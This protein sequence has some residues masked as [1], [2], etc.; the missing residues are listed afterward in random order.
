[1]FLDWCFKAFQMKFHSNGIKVQDSRLDA[2]SMISFSL[3]PCHGTYD[4]KVN[5]DQYI[6]HIDI[7][8]DSVLKTA[9]PKRAFAGIQCF[10]L[11][12][13]VTEPYTSSNISLK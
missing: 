13:G 8:A 7:S 2:M 1:M 12:S 4:S 6:L 9:E 3:L 5:F 11:L 10:G